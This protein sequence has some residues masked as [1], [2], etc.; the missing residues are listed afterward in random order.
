MACV[1]LLRNEQMD[2]SIECNEGKNCTFSAEDKSTE[3]DDERNNI[4]ISKM[5]HES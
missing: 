4:Q 5:E 3:S 1:T 2:N